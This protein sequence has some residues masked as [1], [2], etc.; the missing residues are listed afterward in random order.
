MFLTFILEFCCTYDFSTEDPSIPAPLPIEKC[1]ARDEI[2]LRSTSIYIYEDK[3]CF[4]HATGQNENSSS[5]CKAKQSSVNEISKTCKR[6]SN[7]EEHQA[8]KDDMEGSASNIHERFEEEETIVV[9]KKKGN[10]VF[11]E[12]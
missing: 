12:I 1:K 4:E 2:Q 6:S 10:K 8:A 9:I 3:N 7:F 5:S 11:I